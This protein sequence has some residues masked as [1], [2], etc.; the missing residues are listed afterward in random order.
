MKK[1]VEQDYATL[2]LKN[3]KDVSFCSR[4]PFNCELSKK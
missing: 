2:F 4:A 1:Q 3:K